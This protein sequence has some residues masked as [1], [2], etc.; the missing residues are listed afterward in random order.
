MMNKK[1]FT[2]S[3]NSAKSGIRPKVYLTGFTL[4]EVLIYVFILTVLFTA[5]FSIITWI[6]YAILKN[7]IDKEVLSNARLAISSIISEAVNSEGI[8]NPT[9][10][11]GQ[12]SLETKRYLPLGEKTSYIDFYLDDSGRLCE[13]KESE[14]PFC[15]T[16]D[17]I[18]VASLVFTKIFY[19]Q[20]PSLKIEITV[21][22]K[23]LS[24]E[25]RYESAASLVSTVSFRNY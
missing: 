22:H 25:E 11:P 7:K 2:P 16:S 19:N 20:K 9:T 6:N 1:G 17:S 14:G 15:L 24:G 23:N 3:N 5:S 10:S 8:Y 21:E 18:E 4:I 13:K 12:L